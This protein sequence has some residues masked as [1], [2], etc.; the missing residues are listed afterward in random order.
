M[1]FLIHPYRKHQ[2]YRHRDHGHQHLDVLL[3]DQ[4]LELRLEPRRV[5]HLDVEEIHLDEKFRQ[6]L[7]DEEI[8]LV[9][10][11]HLHQLDEVLRLDGYQIDLVYSC[12]G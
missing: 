8:R 6:H 10:K 1:N 3:E 7:L 11:D 12:L 9:L 5:H 4:N 2:L